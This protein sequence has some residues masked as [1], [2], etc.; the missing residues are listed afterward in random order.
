MD[1]KIDFIKKRYFLALFVFL[2]FIIHSIVHEKKDA[3]VHKYLNEKANQLNLEYHVIYDNYKEIADLVFKT[4]INKPSI[5]ELFKNHKRKELHQKLLTNY[6]TLRTFNIRQLHFHLPNNDSF[7][8]MHRPNKFGDNLSKD[9]LTVKYVNENQKYIHGFEEGKIFNGFR[10]VYPIFDKNEHIGSVE[11]SF[12]ALAFIKDIAKYYKVKS[13]FLIDKSVVSDKVFKDEKS[14]YTNSPLQ[15][16]YFQKSIIDHLGVDLSARVISKSKEQFMY[17]K[18]ELGIPFSIYDKVLKQIVTLIPLKNPI[19]EKVTAVLTFRT[20]DI[21]I[22]AEEKQQL[23][24]F[25]T[26]SML[27][28]LIL[29]LIYKELKYKANLENKVKNRTMELLEVNEKLQDM[30]Y[31]D[32]LTGAYNRHYFYE[33]VKNIISL[34]KREKTP[35]SF[36]MIDIDKFKDINDTYGHDKGD[37]VLKVLVREIQTNI[38]ESDILVRFGGEEFVL[39]FPN[40]SLS[41]ALIISEKLRKIIQNCILVKD[42]RFTISIGVSEYIISKDDI[43][44]VLKK[45]DTALYEAKN[46]G[47]NRVNYKL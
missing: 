43:N 18:I 20:K 4:E 1:L 42:V 29:F 25:L 41:Q 17:K 31:I 23:T 3:I 46:S 19:S 30:A 5:I 6:K 16:Y 34:T 47:R 35:L 2:V 22:T 32:S 15:K 28:G 24:I 39:V 37:D 8:R 11:I 12:S 27:S 36:A 21:V 45:A 38:R 14:N 7:L 13:N 26:L 33:Y 44:S 9:R 10:F 40:T